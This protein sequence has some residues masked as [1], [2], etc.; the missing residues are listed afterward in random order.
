MNFKFIKIFE[1]FNKP[2]MQAP[3]DASHLVPIGQ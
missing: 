1:I 2:W 3:V